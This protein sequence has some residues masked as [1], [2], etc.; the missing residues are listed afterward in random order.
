MPTKKKAIQ[1]QVSQVATVANATNKPAAKK[2]TVAKKATVKRPANVEHQV[3]HKYVLLGVC[4][5]C[6]H[7]PMRAN[8]LVTLLSFVIIVLSGMLIYMLVPLDF[9]FQLSLGQDSPIQMDRSLAQ[10]Q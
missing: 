1:S 6:N 3:H 9:N 4:S 10:S 8:K 5:S 7:L 2:K